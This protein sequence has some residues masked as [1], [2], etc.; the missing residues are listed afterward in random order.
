MVCACFFFLSFSLIGS[1]HPHLVFW[2]Q[3]RSLLV[4]LLIMRGYSAGAATTWLHTDIVSLK[5]QTMC[6]MDNLHLSTCFHKNC[7]HLSCSRPT[8]LTTRHNPLR[9]QRRQHHQLQLPS[10]FPAA[11]LQLLLPPAIFTCCLVAP[12]SHRPRNRARLDAFVT[13]PALCV[14]PASVQ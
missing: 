9:L 13:G 7:W 10:L 11:A 14:R 12:V 1:R 8:V 5:C 2:S 3:P 4:A 6:L